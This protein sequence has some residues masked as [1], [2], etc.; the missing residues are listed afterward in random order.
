M[1]IAVSVSSPTS[2]D[3]RG[4]GFELHQQGRE[5]QEEDAFDDVLLAP[6]GERLRMDKRDDGVF[7]S[8]IFVADNLLSLAHRQTFVSKTIA[9]V[10]D[11]RR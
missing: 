5:R 1:Q 8:A 7:V 11:D 9:G 6:L 2:K 10:P 3:N 4:H